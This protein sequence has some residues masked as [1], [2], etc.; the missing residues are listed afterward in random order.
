MVIVLVTGGSR[1]IEIIRENHQTEVCNNMPWYPIGVH[2]A[3]GSTWNDGRLSICGGT[4]YQTTSMNNCY[5]LENGQW[6]ENNNNLKMGRHRHAASN[7]GTNIWFSGGY[8]GQNNWRLS[9]TEIMHHDG[10]ITS[11]PNLPQKRAGHCQVSYGQSTF[12]IGKCIDVCKKNHECKI[13]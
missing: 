13:I 3:A 8:N 7:I 6:K 2:K 9:S 12:I 10:K 11:G 1:R 5:S 4:V